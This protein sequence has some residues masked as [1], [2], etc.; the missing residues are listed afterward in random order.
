MNTNVKNNI[1][2]I[3]KENQCKINKDL[4]PILLVFLK[5]PFLA[6]QFLFV[7]QK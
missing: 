3:S 4:N 2:C 5:V 1:E 6:Q 7:A